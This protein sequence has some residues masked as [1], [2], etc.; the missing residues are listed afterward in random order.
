MDF[1]IFYFLFLFFFMNTKKNTS[2]SDQHTFHYY[3]FRLLYSLINISY[4]LCH[5]L[6]FININLYSLF[7]IILLEF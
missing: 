3:M 2:E 4:Q 6:L 5:F 7:H 1:V